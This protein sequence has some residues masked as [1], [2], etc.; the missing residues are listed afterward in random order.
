MP[1]DN[2]PEATE[3]P[4][5]SKQV[6]AVV[7]TVLDGLRQAS[8][9][10]GDP[11]K[12]KA[13]GEAA[14]Q[15]PQLLAGL[16]GAALR[17]TDQGVQA[18]GLPAEIAAAKAAYDAPEAESAAAPADAFGE[19]LKRTLGN[20]F[21]EHVHDDSG[22]T[23]DQLMVDPTFVQEHGA[24]LA[25]GLIGAFAKALFANP[26]EFEV[27]TTDKASGDE[28]DVKVKLDLGAFFKALVPAEPGEGDPK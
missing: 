17:Q 14:A 28:K 3:I 9:Q 18:D 1:D 21:A 6:Q 11:A 7:D 26:V 10:G 25:K 16:L 8:T 15:I 12:A 19:E 23:P 27:P 2:K 5:D 4:L 22:R 20:V 13:A 24:D